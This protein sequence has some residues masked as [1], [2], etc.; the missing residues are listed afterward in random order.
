MTLHQLSETLDLSL[1]S[2]LSRFG[3]NQALFLRFLKQFPLDP[4]WQQ[5]CDAAEKQDYPHMEISAHTLKG[6]AA[7]LGL[8]L[9]SYLCHQIV[10]AVRQQEY[11]V[12]P[13]LMQ[14]TSACYNQ[15]CESIQQLDDAY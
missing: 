12:L 9:L 11:D 7:N 5:L 4:T 2:T 14:K 8:D 13:S 3:N 6:V 1:T 15:I 10:S